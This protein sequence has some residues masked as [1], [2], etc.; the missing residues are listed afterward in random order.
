MIPLN[1]IVIGVVAVA[2]VAG[3]WFFSAGRG[4]TGEIDRAGDLSATDLRV[5]DCIDLKD[6]DAEE[7]D[8]VTARP[9][10]VE[11]EYEMFFVGSLPAGP[12]PADDVFMAYLEAN[13]LPGFATYVGK[14]YEDSALDVSWLTPTQAG[15]EDG[16]R[17][18]Q[19]ALYSPNQSR[20]TYSLKGSGF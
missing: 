11:H 7:I 3:G 8:D 10:T 2:T 18:V 9:C 1:W 20:L 5:G 15:W 17:S 6:P 19:C 13:C 16:D 4:T 12:Y 14:A